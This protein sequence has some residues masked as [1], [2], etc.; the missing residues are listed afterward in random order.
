MHYVARLFQ[1]LQSD[2]P[3]ARLSNRG[4]CLATT[5]DVLAHQVPDAIM[6]RPRRRLR[7][8]TSDAFRRADPAKFGHRFFPHL[9][10]P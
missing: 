9:I 5:A 1:H 7:P 2:Y 4:A 3:L 10:S 6:D 8:D